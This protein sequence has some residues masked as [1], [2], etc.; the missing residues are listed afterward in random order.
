[1]HIFHF[2]NSATEIDFVAFYFLLVLVGCGLATAGLI[3]YDAWVDGK[4][5]G[6]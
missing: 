5:Q 3:A 4:G 1:M 2:L 6:Q